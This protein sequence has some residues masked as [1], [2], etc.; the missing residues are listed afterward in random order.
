MPSDYRS[1]YF[2]Q[3][4]LALKTDKS[5]QKIITFATHTEVE[6]VMISFKFLMVFGES[7]RRRNGGI[8][9]LKL[10]FYLSMGSKSNDFRKI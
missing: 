4:V 1:P 9:D 6:Q 5:R 3:S 8:D 2:L 10:K 7:S